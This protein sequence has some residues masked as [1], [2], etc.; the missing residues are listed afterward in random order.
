MKRSLN[1]RE[2]VVHTFNPS[3]QE[4][5]AGGYEFEISLVYRVNFRTPR[6]TQRNPVSN[7]NYYKKYVNFFKDFFYVH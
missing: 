2:V 6:T 5:E 7:N 3:T 1:L 4:A